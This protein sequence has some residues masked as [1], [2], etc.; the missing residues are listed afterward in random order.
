MKLDTHQL[1]LKLINVAI[2]NPPK[3]GVEVGRK[4]EGEGGVERDT[5]R[6]TTSV[7]RQEDK[8]MEGGFVKPSFVPRVVKQEQGNP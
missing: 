5:V 3:R 7:Q 6:H 4:E 1:G 2:S 8:K